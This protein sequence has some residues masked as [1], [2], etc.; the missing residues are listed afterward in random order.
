MY[1]P[2]PYWP[3]PTRYRTPRKKKVFVGYAVL[4]IILASA[5]LAVYSLVQPKFEFESATCTKDIVI[6]RLIAKKG[7]RLFGARFRLVID[8]RSYDELVTRA[9]ESGEEL[10]VI[11]E[12]NLPKGSYDAKLYFRNNLVGVFR[13]RVS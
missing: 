3:Y 13:C 4:A 5:I 11:F 9:V 2:I 7:G 8:G 10:K 12:T 6:A 1:Y